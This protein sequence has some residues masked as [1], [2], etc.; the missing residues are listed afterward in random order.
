MVAMRTYARRRGWCWE[1]R[2]VASRRGQYLDEYAPVSHQWVAS[3][4]RKV[5]PMWDIP[6]GMA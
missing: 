5:S 6:A 1:F 2:S 4:T 3:A